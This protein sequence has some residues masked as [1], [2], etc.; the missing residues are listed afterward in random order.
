MTFCC[1]DGFIRILTMAQW[2]TTIPIQMGSI[3]PYIQQITRVLVTAHEENIFFEKKKGW[4]FSMTWYELSL[5][6]PIFEDGNKTPRCWT[7]SY[8]ATKITCTEVF[9]LGSQPRLHSLLGNALS[10]RISMAITEGPQKR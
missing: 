5:H 4:N 8:P 10:F 9:F 3:F 2:L 1:T 7:F 6:C